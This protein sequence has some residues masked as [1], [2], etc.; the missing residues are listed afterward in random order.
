MMKWLVSILVLLLG[1]SIV[2]AGEDFV[3]ANQH[4][5]SGEYAQ[6]AEVYEGLLEEG[7]RVSVLNNLG[8]AYFRLEEY[9]RAILAFE[10]ALILKPGDPDLVA[11]L[12]LAQEQAAVFPERGSVGGRGFLSKVSPNTLAVIALIAAVMLPLSALVRVR[13]KNGTRW[14]MV[15]L[16][17]NIV[18]IRIALRP[19]KNRVDQE[20]RGVVLA[21]P[22]TVRLSPFE[23]ADSR[24]TLSSGREVVLGES[25]K[26]YFW[27]EANEGATKGWVHGD[28]VARII[29][30]SLSE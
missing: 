27:I 14:A 11:N 28:E 24:A 23:T 8:S 10:R 18:V 21:K 30:V 7:P 19:M 26:G 25:Q 20:S 3:Q 6:A 5:E 22:A 2:E 13:F 4:Y 16:V 12:E 15:L 1:A 17:L 29:P 9:G